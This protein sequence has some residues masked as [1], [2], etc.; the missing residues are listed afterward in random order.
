MQNT[1]KGSLPGL[2]KINNNNWKHSNKDTPNWAHT[3]HKTNLT[4][5]SINNSNAVGKL[6]SL[7]SY[8]SN[9]ILRDTLTM[10]HMPFKDTGLLVLGWYPQAV[11]HVDFGA[12]VGV[13][14]EFPP[15]EAPDAEKVVARFTP[16]DGPAAGLEGLL[17]SHP[18]LTVE[19]RVYEWV[20]CWVEIA[21]PENCCHYHRWAIARA[22][23]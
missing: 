15:A 22:A 17:K 10:D 4:K 23:A 8:S 11:V 13:D 7:N 3:P 5:Q 21:H 19:V 14:V 12:G 1:T 16:H 2:H 18:E 9:H 20:Q 6:N